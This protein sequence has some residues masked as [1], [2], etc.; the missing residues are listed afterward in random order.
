MESISFFYYKD[1]VNPT[2]K[3]KDVQEKI[4]Y[5]AGIKEKDQRIK[6]ICSLDLSH[7]YPDNELFWNHVELKLYD[8]SK[9]RTK[10]TR[11]IYHSDIYLDLYKKIEDLKKSVSEQTKVPVEKLQFK[12]NNMILDNE[13]ILNKYNLFENK[14]SVTISK[15]LNNQIKIKYKDSKEKQIYTDIHNTVVEFLE[16]IDGI[17]DCS[18]IHYNVIYKNQRLNLDSLLTH[19]GIKNG[20]LIEL[21]YRKSEYEIYIK[22]LREN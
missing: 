15:E 19:S 11:G 4:K 21:K 10:L 6:L 18:R 16:E 2:L 8:A 13:K 3:I 20:D 5:M 17:S 12:L 7:N 1:F 14:L 22:T 9:Y